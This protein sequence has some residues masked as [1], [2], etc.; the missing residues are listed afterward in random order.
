MLLVLTTLFNC[1]SHF[2]PYCPCHRSLLLN[3]YTLKPPTIPY[4]ML[5]H[6][7]LPSP[8][9]SVPAYNPKEAYLRLF[10]VTGSWKDSAAAAHGWEAGIYKALREDSLEDAVFPIHTAF[11]F[12]E[13]HSALLVPSVCLQLLSD[14]GA[15]IKLQLQCFL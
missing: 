13:H 5:P 8:A 15:S 3:P 10:S 9:S 6:P 7:A 2:I 11:S 4:T 12:A 1:N 14:Y